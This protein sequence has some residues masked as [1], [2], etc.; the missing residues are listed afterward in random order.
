MG[1]Y[2]ILKKFGSLL[3][4]FLIFFLSSMGLMMFFSFNITY[5][6]FV[7]VLLYVY[8]YSCLLAKKISQNKVGLFLKQRNFFWYFK[9][10]IKWFYRYVGFQIILSFEK[11]FF[12]FSIQLC[13][14]K[15][16]IRM[17]IIWRL[18]F[19][20]F[21]KRENELKMFFIRVNLNRFEL[22]QKLLVL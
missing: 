17:W 9:S 12:S 19:F 15:W 14:F 4:K 10:F 8:S 13:I 1:L 5:T 7:V 11:L 16:V 18:L 2:R 20:F 22:F 6:I 21:T 3:W